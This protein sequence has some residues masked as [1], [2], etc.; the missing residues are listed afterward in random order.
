MYVHV[1]NTC[2]YA[3]YHL[4]IISL[5]Y[6]LSLACTVRSVPGVKGRLCLEKIIAAMFS[7]IPSTWG[8]PKPEDSQDCNC[9]FSS[10][11]PSPPPPPPLPPSL[12]PP[13]F[14]CFFSSSSS[15]CYYHTQVQLHSGNDGQ[16]FPHQLMAVPRTTLQSSHRQP[17][18]QGERN[19]L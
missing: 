18:S 15:S 1:P 2:H 17:S 8:T 14:S 6:F 4:C 19:I 16:G 5:A 7:P 13:P 10:S 3:L 9:S 11:S 12:P